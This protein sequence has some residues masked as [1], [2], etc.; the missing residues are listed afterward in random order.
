MLEK[1][2]TSVW[3]PFCA[4]LK[5]DIE[6]GPRGGLSR[7]TKKMTP[8]SQKKKYECLINGGNEASGMASGRGGIGGGIGG[9]NGGRGCIAGVEFQR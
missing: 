6:P 9:S 1:K 4:H 2:T 5:R 3:W 8:A 7:H